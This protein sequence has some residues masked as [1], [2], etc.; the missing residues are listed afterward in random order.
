[1][2]VLESWPD[3]KIKELREKQRIRSIYEACVDLILK[4]WEGCDQPEAKF[5]LENIIRYGFT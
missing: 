4:D 2:F 3:Q 1:M 5:R